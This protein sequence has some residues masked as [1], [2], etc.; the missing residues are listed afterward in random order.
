L[1]QNYRTDTRKEVLGVVLDSCFRSF[2]QLAVEIGRRH[3]E[4]PAF[5]IKMGYY[6]IRVTLEERGS[7]KIAELEL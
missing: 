6:L 7:F 4:V 1:V 5:L 2:E 3:S